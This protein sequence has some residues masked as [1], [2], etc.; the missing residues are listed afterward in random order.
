[1]DAAKGGEFVILH[2]LFRCTNCFR[3]RTRCNSRL[4]VVVSSIVDNH[5]TNIVGPASSSQGN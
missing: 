4:W 3:S 5:L 1:L 2:S